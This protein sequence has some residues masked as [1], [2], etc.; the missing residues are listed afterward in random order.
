ML[1]IDTQPLTQFSG[2]LPVSRIEGNLPTSRI[3]NFP[4]SLGMT[5]TGH[6]GNSRI[7]FNT[8]QVYLPYRALLYQDGIK[9]SS[10]GENN[11]YII[12][13]GLPFEGN[14]ANKHACAIIAKTRN[15]YSRSKY[16]FLC[17]SIC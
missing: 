17:I 11:D 2:N 10:V 8:G 1:D 5:L 3:E 14:I 4:S 9:L 16:V 12:Q 15:S 6:N 13:F 7:T